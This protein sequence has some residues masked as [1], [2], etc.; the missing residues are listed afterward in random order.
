[1][2]FR[3]WL[4]LAEASQQETQALK[5][6]GGDEKAL[7]Q[8][9]SISPEPKFLPAL[10]LLHREQ[11][12]LEQ[13]GRDW[14]EYKKL[15]DQKKM[16]P[17]AVQ[18][19]KIVTPPQNQPMTYLQ[20]TEKVHA[21]SSDAELV[22]KRIDIDHS[23]SKAP[24][25]K[26]DTLEV[27]ETDGPGDCIRYGKG[28]SFCISQP[29]NTMWQSYRDTQTSTFYFV[30][31][32]SRPETDPL[33]IVVV[34]MAKDGPK[35]TDA[36]NTTGNI[37]EHGRNAEAYLQYLYSK[38]VPKDLLRNK[39]HTDEEKEESRLLGHANYNTKWFKDLS[40]DHK[41]KY[42]GRGHQLTDEQFDYIFDNGME[43]LVKQYA[44]IG[45]KLNDHQMERM[46]DSKFRSTYLHFRLVT[47]Q[48]KNDLDVREY[49]RLSDKQKASL[50]DDVKFAMLLKKG[51]RDEAMELLP[52]V[53]SRFAVEAAAEVGDVELLN[54]FDE[55]GAI[56][57]RYLTGPMM[58]A[59]KG[60]SMESI[61]WLL[62]KGG[63]PK[64]AFEAI[65]RK[66]DLALLQKA[67][68]KAEEWAER[69]HEKDDAIEWL[70]KAAH[71]AAEMGHHEVF[72]H[73]TDPQNGL[74]DL[75][76][77]YRW[78]K[79]AESLLSAALRSENPT[80][81]DGQ[82]KIVKSMLDQ[83]FKFAISDLMH[84]E[85]ISP[86]IVELL[87]DMEAQDEKKNR[88]VS[89]ML[90]NLARQGNLG[91]VRRMAEDIEKRGMSAR[92]R[93]YW[94]LIGAAAGGSPEILDF[95]HDELGVREIN[96]FEFDSIMRYAISR[97]EK[98]SKVMDWALR[99]GA[100]LNDKLVDAAVNANKPNAVR[101]LVERMG[102]KG[103]AALV[104]SVEEHGD[105]NNFGPE[106]VDRS[107]IRKYADSLTR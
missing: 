12:D 11:P 5:M 85:R 67:L 78:R 101:W 68:R 10:A 79:M 76:Q 29:G 51:S 14:A 36:R 63:P 96:D 91:A 9:K 40:P 95:V 42:I 61:A 87:L 32:K 3:P 69:N 57:G 19:D 103:V 88:F 80:D 72:K 30:Y 13:L 98:D 33:H 15:L 58:A 106:P 82:I 89:S 93:A 105:K 97:D 20:W 100:E 102:P 43:S 71:A 16:P 8:L 94:I 48:H 90:E 46:L 62:D 86:H 53:S 54:H 64:Y 49:D 17:L 38:G 1:M 28:Y 26:N 75:K 35:L 104:K 56:D 59:A 47:N 52:K 39:E 73:L 50:G 77:D 92:R 2:E 41:S 45:R 23:Q 7:G 24:I 83:G 27:Y 70:K 25:F 107:A 55:K 31:D 44:E 81:K 6:L 66:G 37:A 4:L 22:K 60:G 21:M 99:K 18:G 34:D 74:V 65:A 84:A